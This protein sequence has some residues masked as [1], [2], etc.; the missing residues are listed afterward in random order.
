MYKTMYL[1]YLCI[2]AKDRGQTSHP[3]VHSNFLLLSPRRS[4][5]TGGFQGKIE[6]LKYNN[7]PGFICRSSVKVKWLLFIVVI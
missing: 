7:N 5:Q 1:N 6:I 2:T 4:I 3:T